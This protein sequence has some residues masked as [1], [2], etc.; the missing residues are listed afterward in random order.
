MKKDDDALV[1][2]RAHWGADERQV[3]REHELVVAA[4]AQHRQ[5]IL[6]AARPQSEDLTEEW[7]GM[8][9]ASSAKTTD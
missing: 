8:L 4:E 1:L 5:C 2:E 9:R 3:R 7:I 6:D